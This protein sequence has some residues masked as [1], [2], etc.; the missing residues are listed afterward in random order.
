MGAG[1]WEAPDAG[2][3]DSARQVV[4]AA[5]CR[6]ASPR[7]ASA[8]SGDNP[9]GVSRNCLPAGPWSC[10]KTCAPTHRARFEHLICEDPRGLGATRLG[11]A[12]WSTGQHV[13]RRGTL[14]HGVPSGRVHPYAVHGSRLRTFANPNRDITSAK[15]HVAVGGGG[16]GVSVTGRRRRCG[17]RHPRPAVRAVRAN[18]GSARFGVVLAVAPRGPHRAPGRTLWCCSERVKRVLSVVG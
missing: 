11:G 14:T 7:R 4:P 16:A 15:W 1:T 12:A 8:A 18:R 10:G 9:D 13:P 6:R 5:R 2:D 17:F 3:T